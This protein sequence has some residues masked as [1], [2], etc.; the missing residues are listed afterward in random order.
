MAADGADNT[1]D[2][3]VV[4]GGLSGLTTATELLRKAPDL[5]VTVVEAQDRVGGRTLTSTFSD[6][7]PVDLGGMW[8]GPT[9]TRIS[10]LVKRFGLVRE[11]QHVKGKDVLFA[12]GKR[13][14]YS[15]LLPPHSLR[16]LYELQTK[17]IWKID[18]LAKSIP[19]HGNI[20]HCAD[21]AELRQMSVAEWAEKTLQTQAA[22]DTMTLAVVMTFGVQP[23]QLSFL[24]FLFYVHAA[25]GITQLVDAEGCAQDARI[26]GGSQQLS[27]RLV[28]DLL[29][30]GGTLNLGIAVKCIRVTQPTTDGAG[31]A[32]QPLPPMLSVACS[33]GRT[34]QCTAVV[35]AVAPSIAHET[36][37]FEPALPA[38]R[39]DVVALT[40]RGHYSKFILRFPRAWWREKGCSGNAICATPTVENPVSAIFDYCHRAVGQTHA[41]GHPAIVAFVAGDIAQALSQLDA[42]E[43]QRRV[44]QHALQMLPPCD[45]A[46]TTTNGGAENTDD[47]AVA[48]DNAAVG[49]AAD[50]GDGTAASSPAASPTSASAPQPTEVLEKEWAQDA[51]AGGCPVDV[52]PPAARA[53]G[54]DVESGSDEVEAW[55]NKALVS[56]IV[57]QPCFF[58]LMSE[59]PKE[60]E[61]EADSSHDAVDASA[62]SPDLPST[63]GP[64]SAQHTVPGPSLFFASTETATIWNGYMEGAVQAGERAAAEVL[65]HLSPDPSD[66]DGT[67]PATGS[68]SDAATTGEGCWVLGP[69]YDDRLQSRSSAFKSCII[70]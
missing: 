22:I 40:R 52:L 57:R 51:F 45:K 10:A 8:Y 3:V 11:P 67:R 47:S 39:V 19:T 20:E 29:V 15:G 28:T 25:G 66:S 16:T 4:G 1:F 30:A 59:T 55:L 61:S 38:A 12:D 26:E 46:P 43:R 5:R 42:A 48:P 7:V 62:Q 69:A 9:Q 33:N 56:R 32:A 44:I 14:T 65:Q 18:A 35:M 54:N 49:V 68:S 31:G 13:K 17:L 41:A 60:Q 63:V 53:P 23:T 58:T 34:L 24:H 36:I 64:S 6:G 2:V 70:S 37:A 27:Q 21:I 50:G